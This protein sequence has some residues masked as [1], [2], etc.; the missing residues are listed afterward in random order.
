MCT[1]CASVKLS[2]TAARL[3]RV[4]FDVPCVKGVMRPR[5]RE[6]KSVRVSVRA[7]LR[8]IEVTGYKAHQHHQHHQHAHTHK[9]MSQGATKWTNIQVDR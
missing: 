9:V 8:R 6:N 3:S 2:F 1:R 5:K 4:C 7:G